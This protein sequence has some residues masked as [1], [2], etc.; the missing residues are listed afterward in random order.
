MRRYIY[1]TPDIFLFQG[2]Q[3]DLT[4]AS[5]IDNGFVIRMTILQLSTCGQPGVQDLAI[6]PDRKS[7]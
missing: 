5:W 1:I 6:N 4:L 3:T 7:L 2:S